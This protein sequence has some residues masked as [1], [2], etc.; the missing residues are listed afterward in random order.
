MKAFITGPENTEEGM[1][2]LIKENGKYLSNAYVKDSDAAHHHF[3][4]NIK[5]ILQKEGVTEVLL[6]SE[7][8]ITAEELTQRNEQWAKTQA[9]NEE[10]TK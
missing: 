2:E 10:G 9:R 5:D 1:Y 4:E 7:S 3:S 6:L 8:S